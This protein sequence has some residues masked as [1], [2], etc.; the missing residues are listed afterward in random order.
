MRQKKALM[1]ASVASMID[2]FNMDNIRIL[3]SLGYEVQV[4]ANFAFGSIT[5]QERVEAFRQELEE[6]GI[7]TWD[8]P[9]PRSIGDWK[10]I[11]R[12]YQM[13]CGLCDREQYSIVHTQSPIGGVVGRL[14]AR[15]LRKKGSHVIYTAHGFHFFDG[16]PKK[17]WLLFYP[18]E[19]F[20]SRYTDILITIN[21]EDYK[22]AQKFHAKNVCYV[23]GI[24]VDVDRFGQVSDER[25]R[26]RAEF[27]FS[28][29]DFVVMSVGQLSRRKNQ[30]TVIRAMAQIPDE[31]IL[32]L[33][34]GQ[35]EMEE[36]DRE[37]IRELGL[38]KRVILAGYRGDIDQL[39]HMADGFVFPSL[40][41]GLPVALMEAMAAGIP[42]ICSK[43]RGNTDLVTDGQ[44]GRLADPLDVAGFSEAIMELKEY[45]K[46]R[47]SY[48]RNAKEKIQGFAIGRVHEEMEQIYRSIS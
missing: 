20:L 30:E 35:G 42:V 36:K 37:L 40:Q 26:L 18:V 33:I 8:I 29:Q 45:P 10:N 46:L 11:S 47:E 1:M 31:R 13:L 43:I 17:N 23:P 15:R 12:S 2:L 16:A 19:K 28:E 39:L 6:A 14:A 27:G 7:K 5:S 41:E 4:A 32:Y 44:E 9:V 48:S 34:V 22:R 24:G 38:Q 3:Q 25:D 21:Q